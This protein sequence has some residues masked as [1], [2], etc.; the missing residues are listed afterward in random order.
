MGEFLAKNLIFSPGKK[1]PAKACPSPRQLF[2][3][4]GYKFRLSRQ[5]AQPIFILLI[6]WFFL[7][8]SPAF[9]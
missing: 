5:A 1:S 6:F 8:F 3:P 7:A 2:T 9:L 4:K